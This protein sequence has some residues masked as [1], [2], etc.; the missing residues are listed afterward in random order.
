MTNHSSASRQR[1]IDYQAR[2][3]R[4]E[5]ALAPGAK[6]KPSRRRSFK[7]LFRLFWEMLRGHRLMFLAAL[8]TLSIGTVV[9]LT[10]PASTKI[11]LDYILP[12]NVE[13]PAFTPDWI[14]QSEPGRLLWLLSGAMIAVTILTVGIGIWGRWQTTRLTKR[15]QVKIRRRVYEHAVRLPMHRVHDL[16]SGGVASILREDAGGAAELLFSM[17]YNPWRAVVQLTA[18]LLILGLLDWQLLIGA[19]LI[20]PLIFVSHRTWIA[21]LRPLYRDIRQSRTSI[22][23]HATETFGGMRVVRGFGREQ[24]EAARFVRETDYMIRQELLAWWWSRGIELV[25]Q[26]MIPIASAALLIYGG[27]RIL[28]GTM[29]FGDLMMFSAYLLMLLGPLEALA[30]SATRIQSNLA[31]FDRILDLL[32]EPREFAEF[33]GKHRVSPATAQGRIEIDGLWF[34]YPARK[35]STG[36]I[37]SDEDRNDPIEDIDPDVDLASESPATDEP[38]WVLQDITLTIEPGQTIAIVGPSGAGKTTLCSLIARLYDPQRGEIRFDGIDLRDIEIASYR[39]LLGIVEQ[40][41]FLFDGTILQNI[42]YGRRGCTRE[43]V[44]EA[45]KAA[46]AHSFI[47]D[48]DHGYDELIGERGVRLSGGQKQRVA[49]ARAILADPTILILDEATS[50]LDTESEMLIQQSLARLM[51]DRT[52]FVIAHRL[53]TVRHADRIVVVEDGQI[54]ETGSHDELLAHDGRY[55]EF[56]KMQIGSR[57]VADQAADPAPPASSPHTL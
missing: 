14:A 39:S 1:Y 13:W 9:G 36:S 22:D 56:L 41:V 50:S 16:K 45:A 32:E 30:A 23:A 4:G 37:G 19:M 12:S 2:L 7:Q 24:G 28:N 49:I 6:K 18:T 43:Q 15:I 35:A 40:D 34:A 33:D 46:N 29:T 57:E 54:L 21:R 8:A 55:A 27:S 17:M 47:I 11:A 20:L 42:S 25:W 38:R 5:S 48:L 3:K 31:G 10:L 51:R 52:S 26:L 44:V 53:S